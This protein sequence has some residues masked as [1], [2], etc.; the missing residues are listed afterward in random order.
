MCVC[1][2]VCVRD[3]EEIKMQNKNKGPVGYLSVL[4][5]A[6]QTKTIHFLFGMI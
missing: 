6:C 5:Q 3:K 4:P 2:C 1:V